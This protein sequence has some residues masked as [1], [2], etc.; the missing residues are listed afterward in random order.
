VE[1]IN[2]FLPTVIILLSISMFLFLYLQI[3]LR[4]AWKDKLKNVEWVTKNKW[5]VVLFAGVPFENIWAPVFEELLFRA[6]III[7]FG[8]LSGYAWLGIG[9]S[10]V[11]FS[12]IHYFGK[13]IYFLDVLEKSGNG[14]ND[15]NNMAE[16]VSN[17]QKEKQGEMK[18]R[19]PAAIVATL[20]LG[21]VAGY[22]GIKYQSIYVSVGID[23]AWNLFMPIF[24]WIVILLSLALYWKVGDTWRYKLRRRRS[25]Y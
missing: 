8:A 22:F 6:P 3:L 23:A 20:I 1:R 18:F 24:I 2:Q 17:L 19:K 7:A 14:N 5:R 21:I 15:T 9:A 10:A 4:R 12:A 11:L 13:H 16:M 25:I